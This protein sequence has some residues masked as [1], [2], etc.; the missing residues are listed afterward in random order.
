[1]K[2]N[3]LILMI[4]LLTLPEFIV[5]FFLN[6]FL[7]IGFLH[8]I[9]LIYIIIISILIIRYIISEIIFRLFLKDK[10]IDHIYNVLLNNNFPNPCNYYIDD[11]ISYFDQ[12]WRNINNEILDNSII[13]KSTTIYVETK[14]LYDL[15]K[16]WQYFRFKNCLKIAVKKYMDINF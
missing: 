5:W 4:F 3:N 10:I 13:N 12:V 15:N 9:F 8:T 1:M 2:K 16:F 6:N 11:W 14:T 7:N